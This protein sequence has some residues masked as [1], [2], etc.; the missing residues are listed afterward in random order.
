M[1]QI[2]ETRLSNEQFSPMITI[3]LLGV[4]MVLSSSSSSSCHLRHRHPRRRPRRHPR[5]RRRHHRHHRHHR[6]CRRHRHRHRR[7]SL[8][9]AFIFHSFMLQTMVVRYLHV[10]ECE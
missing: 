2:Q 4:D 6:R 10:E 9:S 1:G 3:P 8:T 7:R 5:R